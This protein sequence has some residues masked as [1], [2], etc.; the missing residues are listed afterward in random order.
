VEGK[1]IKIRRQERKE[2]INYWCFFVFCTTL[3]SPSPKHCTEYF[4][5]PN[6][7]V[8]S[9]LVDTAVAGGASYSVCGTKEEVERSEIFKQMKGKK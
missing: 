8:T 3:L 5:E 1:R 2:M 6:E 9:K 7:Q 4:G